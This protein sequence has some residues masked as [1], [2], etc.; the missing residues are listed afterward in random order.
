MALECP[1]CSYSVDESTLTAESLGPETFA[2]LQQMDKRGG[3][4]VLEMDFFD[5]LG[6][7]EGCVFCPRCS[8][9]F[10]IHG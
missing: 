3:A 10:P 2:A 1:H 5:V 9:E 8:E 6:A 7:D 4:G